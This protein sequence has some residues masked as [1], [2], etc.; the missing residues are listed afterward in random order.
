[1]PPSGFAWR[2]DMRT[3]FFAGAQHIFQS[4]VNA[5]RAEGDN[6]HVQLAAIDEELKQ[7][8]I[9]HRLRYEPAAG[10]A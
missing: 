1:M 2:N 6:Q 8:I 7:F 5:A 10:S 3:A 4:I 9:E